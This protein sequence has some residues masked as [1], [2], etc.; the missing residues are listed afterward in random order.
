MAKRCDIFLDPW[1]PEFLPEEPANV[2][3]EDDL[4]G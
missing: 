3:G 1:P 2:D 4:N